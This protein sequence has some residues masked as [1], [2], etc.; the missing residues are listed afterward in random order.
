ME[1][2]IGGRLSSS[3]G[4]IVN[5]LSTCCIDAKSEDMRSRRV[6]LLVVCLL[7]SLMATLLTKIL[8]SFVAFRCL[9]RFRGTWYSDGG[10]RWIFEGVVATDVVAKVNVGMVLSFRANFSPN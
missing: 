8:V 10:C 4:R 3:N 6:R 7:G 5:V 9:V 2:R 1:L